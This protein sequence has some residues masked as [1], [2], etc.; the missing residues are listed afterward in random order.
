MYSRMDPET[1]KPTVTV[2]KAKDLDTG[3]LP[4]TKHVEFEELRAALATL[5]GLIKD[6][7]ELAGFKTC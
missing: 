2:L 4:D 7:Q 1:K 3:L 6:F 5:G